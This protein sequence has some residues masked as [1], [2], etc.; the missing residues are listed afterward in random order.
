MQGLLAQQALKVLYEQ[1][2]NNKQP[3]LVPEKKIIL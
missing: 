3:I 2:N 1:E